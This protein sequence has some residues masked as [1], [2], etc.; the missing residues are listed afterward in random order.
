MES[1]NVSLPIVDY[2]GVGLEL[3]KIKDKI[4]KG[5][6]IGL[7]EP[8]MLL[9]CWTLQYILENVRNKKNKCWK[10]YVIDIGSG[11]GYID[12]ILSSVFKIGVYC[13]DSDNERLKSSIRLQRL[14]NDDNLSVYNRSKL[15]E[16]SLME[17]FRY[18]M[19]S[20]ED[21]K[22]IW[23]KSV[24]FFKDLNRYQNKSNTLIDEIVILALKVCGDMI[25]H[26]VE[27]V[28][29]NLKGG[30]LCK[31]AR[32]V[33]RLKMFLVPCCFH[34]SEVL[35][36]SLNEDSMNCEK[37][38]RFLLSWTRKQFEQI[39]TDSIIRCRICPEAGNNYLGIEIEL[40]L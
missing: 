3:I 16:L 36:E 28:I 4:P 32:E 6:F 1:I 30:H 34:K 23:D 22:L 31:C 25:F 12:R 2:E 21:F 39:P 5:Y 19:K 14:L 40:D 29:L 38:G 17:S 7:S 37:V 11:K 10:Q 18:E 20:A 13:V 9:I 35:N 24:S 33:K 8:H 15:N 27:W 26:I